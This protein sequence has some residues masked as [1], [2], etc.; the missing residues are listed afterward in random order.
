MQGYKKETELLTKL[1]LEILPIL[2]AQYNL[3]EYQ[4]KDFRT[5][6]IACMKSLLSRLKHLKTSK[7]FSTASSDEDLK[8]KLKV[9]AYEKTA[10]NDQKVI[11][12]LKNKEKGLEQRIRELEKANKEA[13]ALKKSM[14]RKDEKLREV[15]RY[16]T[17]LKAKLE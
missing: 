2:K 13:V 14:E 1:L 8:L 11:A 4:S 17:V 10:K 16:N 3:E 15:M 5:G 12:I 9:D 6:D 7:F